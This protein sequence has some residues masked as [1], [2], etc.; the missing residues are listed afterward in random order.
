[1]KSANEEFEKDIKGFCC[2]V[3]QIFRKYSWSGNLRELRGVIRRAVLL[4]KSEWITSGELLIQV[5]N[6]PTES[7]SLDNEFIMRESIVKMLVITDNNK[8]KA[9]TLLGIA[10]STLYARMKKYNIE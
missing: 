1:M 4:A 2:E 9:A 6:N 8:R 10:R 5:D 7:N 3:Q